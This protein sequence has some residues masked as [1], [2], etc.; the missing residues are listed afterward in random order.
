MSDSVGLK[1]FPDSK[2]RE[3]AVAGDIA[4]MSELGH[5]LIKVEKYEEAL[6]F[7]VPAAEKGDVHAQNN[8]GIL[9]FNGRGILKNRF[10]ACGWFRKAAEQGYM[11]AQYNLGICYANGDGVSRD[12]TEA[13]KWLEKAAEQGHVDAQFVLGTIYHG[14]KSPN[15]N[16]VKAFQLY[17]RAMNN[18][19][20]TDA[21]REKTI[22]YMQI[23]LIDCVS[24][25]KSRSAMEL[26]HGIEVKIP[27]GHFIVSFRPEKASSE[28]PSR[29]PDVS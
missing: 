3:H 10:I 28:A 9:R 7:I 23:L 22:D 26:R 5:H 29:A 11:P 18:P 25:R 20:A 1:K 13:I 24:G 16:L 6:E 19:A 2:L 15:R 27:G 14:E 17:S 8:L 12:E 21:M 4:S